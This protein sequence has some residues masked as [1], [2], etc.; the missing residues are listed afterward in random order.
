MSLGVE[1]Y[2]AVDLR[3][4]VHNTIIGLVIQI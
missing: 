2:L 1:H 3:V 4:I